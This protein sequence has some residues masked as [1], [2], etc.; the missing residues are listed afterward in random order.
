MTADGVGDADD[1]WLPALTT[2]T[3]AVVPSR[4]STCP[5]AT[6]ALDLAVTPNRLAILPALADAPRP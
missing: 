6:A 2:G 1:D 5:D 3:V 4:I